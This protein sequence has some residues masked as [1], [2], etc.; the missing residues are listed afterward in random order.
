VE[1]TSIMAATR[2]FAL[3]FCVG[4]TLAAAW[5]PVDANAANY[6][7]ATTGNDANPGTLSQPFRTIKRGLSN[8][9][10]GDTLYLRAGR[11]AEA[12]NSHYQVVPA[13]TSWTSPVTVAAYPGETATI[14]GHI[15]I[16]T[17]SVQYVVF[18]G[19]PGSYS[20]VLEGGGI[21]VVHA[22]GSAP[23][24]SY[25]RFQ[26][27][28]VRNTNNIQG[29]FIYANRV[30]V[31]NSRIHDVRTDNVAIQN[32]DVHCFY[33]QGAF[34]IIDGNEI[35][36]CPSYGI[37]MYNG[38]DHASAHSNIIRN[39][40]IHHVTTGPYRAGGGAM[41][42]GSGSNNLV[43]NNVLHDNPG[44]GIGVGYGGSGNQIY[45]N[46]IYKT[47]SLGFALD[48]NGVSNT[49][50]RNN[51]LYENTHEIKDGTSTTTYSNNL[52][53]TA[54]SACQFRVDPRFVNPAALN[55]R[56]HQLS[57]I[58]D[59]GVTVS[60]VATDFDRLPRPRGSAYDL[61]AFEYQGG[62]GSGP[63]AP[64]NVRIVQ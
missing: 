29:V 38:Y 36:N 37:H 48:I 58:I 8:L 22:N 55:F 43:Y 61:G 45:N 7:V 14:A 52:C 63:A 12:I 5:H 46:T 56:L 2:K 18:R 25:I 9:R 13:G 53:R 15:T 41:I 39:N 16:G 42:V 30:E 23:G 57:P 54:T 59:K 31:L 1:E 32:G 62:S 40:R 33:I 26:N 35:Y 64:N 44:G 60:A 34:T 28:E 17:P 6:Y 19:D 3:A 24:N 11:Y 47:G 4:L 50:V 10:P 51:I 27:M 21:A 49:I 20:L